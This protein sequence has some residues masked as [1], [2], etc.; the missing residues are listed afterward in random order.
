MVSKLDT[1]DDIDVDDAV[2]ASAPLYRSALRSVQ[3]I[4]EWGSFST[5][6]Q[7]LGYV[8]FCTM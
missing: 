7:S 4:S 1:S 6:L 5:T 3:I 2:H 8:Q